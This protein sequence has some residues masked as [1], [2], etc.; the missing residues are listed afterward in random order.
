MDTKN[1]RSESAG[2]EKYERLYAL[3]QKLLAQTEEIKNE[4]G[5]IASFLRGTVKK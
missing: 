2:G 5:E 3:V 4:T 1:K